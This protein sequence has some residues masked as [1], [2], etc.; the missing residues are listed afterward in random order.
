MA[1]RI[2]RV[3]KSNS[4]LDYINKNPATV[5][6]P[7]LGIAGT[8]LVINTRKQNK[9]IELQSQQLK[10]MEKLTNSLNKVD[11]T[12]KDTLVEDKNKTTNIK[13]GDS[14]LVNLF[15]KK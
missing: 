14:I 13:R 1:I 9:N 3:R 2:K 10:A 6:V 4:V 11:K 8:G 7:A 15:N 12:V 5:S